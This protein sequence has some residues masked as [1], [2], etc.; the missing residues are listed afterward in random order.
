MASKSS[1]LWPRAALRIEVLVADAHGFM[2][3]DPYLTFDSYQ[4]IL[5]LLGHQV[6]LYET[7]K[8]FRGLGGER[9]V[10]SHRADGLDRGHG[11]AVGVSSS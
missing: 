3:I 1:G 7:N 5:E 6:D 9:R 8:V 4:V 11:K 2:F 10:N